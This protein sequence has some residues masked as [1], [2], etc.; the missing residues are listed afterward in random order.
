[1]TRN[2]GAGNRE[3]ET[4]N[5]EECSPRKALRTFKLLTTSYFELQLVSYQQLYI[6]TMCYPK[7]ACQ[8]RR[9]A[10]ANTE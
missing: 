6:C 10:I 4:T 7:K 2:G 3:P 5:C 1:M 8:E 9:V